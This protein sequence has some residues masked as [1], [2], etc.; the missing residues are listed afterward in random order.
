MEVSESEIVYLAPKRSS[1]LKEAL[2]RIIMV[3][4]SPFSTYDDIGVSPEILGPLIIVLLQVLFA[5]LFKYLLY[6][7]IGIVRLSF[8]KVTEPKINVINDTLYV[9]YNANLT[10]PPKATVSSSLNLFIN[11]ISWLI[12]FSFLAVGIRWLIIGLV[13]YF[14]IILFRGETRGIASG[15]GYLLSVSLVQL[16]ITGLLQNYYPK[17]I[18]SVVVVLP[19]KVN[20]LRDAILVNRALLEW[21]ARSV[22]L[23]KYL[24]LINW[25][26]IL[27]QGV[28]MVALF[29]GIAK[30]SGTKSII[31]AIIAIIASSLILSPI[32][33]LLTPYV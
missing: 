22:Y 13:V 31:A 2:K 19:A 28:L 21:F 7:H 9:C 6:L 14:L 16:I 25:F 11:Y 24:S 4:I 26:M 29:M 17:N 1:V 20:V 33:R 23:L 12:L 30:L 3:V 10:L 15:T 5:V 27:W 8:E 18:N 32:T